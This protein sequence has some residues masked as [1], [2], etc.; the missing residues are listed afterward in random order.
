MSRHN[1]PVKL[2]QWEATRLGPDSHAIDILVSVGTGMPS[3]ETE[4]DDARMPPKSAISR[5]VQGLRSSFDCEKQS[6]EYHNSLERDRRENHFRLNPLIHD[7]AIDL[8]AV[9]RLKEMKH[10]AHQPQISEQV[11]RSLFALLATSFYLELDSVPTRLKSGL[12]QCRATI[13]FRLPGPQLM[14]LLVRSEQTELEFV[15]QSQRLGFLHPQNDVCQ[16]CHRFRKDVVLIVPHMQER[17]TVEL[18]SPAQGR[19]HISA[20]PQTITS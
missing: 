17:V 9:D 11:G 13:K 16:H 3:T 2:A 10:I 5:L 14:E 15:T 12:L 7:G 6:Q 19:R 4:V 1:N 8:D 18:Q 20:F